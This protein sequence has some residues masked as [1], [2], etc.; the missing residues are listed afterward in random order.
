MACVCRR[1]I[2]PYTLSRGYRGNCGFLQCH[3]H[4]FRAVQIA[5]EGA[6]DR[7]RMRIVLR[8]VIDDTRQTG[9]HVA[10]AKIFGADDFAR[11]GFHQRRGR[12]GRSSPDF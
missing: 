6:G 11:R 5:D 9:M 4:A 7:E 10:A 12:R 3:R 8:E 2:T 1:G